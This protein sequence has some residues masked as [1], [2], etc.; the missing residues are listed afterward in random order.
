MIE[1]GDLLRYR[2]EGTASADCLEAV[3]NYLDASERVF[4]RGGSLATVT[5]PTVWEPYQALTEWC[6]QVFPR[7]RYQHPLSLPWDELEEQFE[8]LT[9][10][11]ARLVAAVAADVQKG[12]AESGNTR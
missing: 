3:A 8:T 12:P 5:H 10:T 2:E 11:V 9:Q 4:R 7:L 1:Y 6:R